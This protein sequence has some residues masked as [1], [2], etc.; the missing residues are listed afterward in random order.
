M[1]YYLT[2]NF[3]NIP[4]NKYKFF[5]QKMP[6]IYIIK[7]KKNNKC[8]IGQTKYS[9]NYR[10]KK[11]KEKS[12]RYKTALYRA[13]DKYG[14]DNFYIESLLQ[15]EFSQNELNKLEVAFIKKYKTLSPSGYNLEIGGNNSPMSEE[16]KL[17]L[18]KIHKGRKIFW[19]NKVS[20]G[21]KKLWEDK[22]YREKQI[23]QRCQKRGKY[24]EGIIKP[25]RLDLPIEDMRILYDQGW[26][27]NQIAKKYKV[28]FEAIKKRLY[29]GQIIRKNGY[30][31]FPM[32]DIKK[33]IQSGCTKK[34]I[35][36][37]YKISHPT[38]NKRLN[39]K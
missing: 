20:K 25:F 37:K 15:G 12:K 3:T 4:L 11:H 24:R 17:K 22:E 2:F 16:T 32:K 5:I 13:F 14:L 21:V 8:Y 9:L 35:M 7:N 1:E 29:R 38:L 18:R 10:F 33:D 36:Q 28:S 26:S 27:I 31:D 30:K 19:A 34:S 23:K 6:H 39:E